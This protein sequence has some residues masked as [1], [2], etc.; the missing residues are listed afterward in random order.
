MAVRKTKLLR[1]VIEIPR[2]IIFPDGFYLKSAYSDSEEFHV[3]PI[4]VQII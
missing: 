2:K 4:L 3:V 1:H